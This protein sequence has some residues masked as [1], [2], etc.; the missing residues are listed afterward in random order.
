MR[1]FRLFRRFR[2]MPHARAAGRRATDHAIESIRE[3]ERA[4]IAR[5]LHDDLGQL[6][7]TLR[8]DV[9]L[10]LQRDAREPGVRE[11]LEGMDRRLLSA[12]VSLR[13]IASNLRPLVLDEGGLYFALQSLRNEFERRHGITCLLDAQESELMFDDYFSTAVYRIV[14]ESL[15]N[16]AR[17]AA[18]ESVHVALRRD[19]VALQI[20]IDDDGRGI[21]PG[22]FAKGT[23]FGLLGM[24]ER[25][26]ALRGDIDISG[27]ATGTRIHVALPLP[28]TF[29]GK[30]YP[31]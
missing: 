18:A 11:Q 29:S 17:H 20:D 6:L 31:T 21:R 26:Q 15:T 3:D 5:E 7:A 4:F 2:P 16:V 19:H 12:I 14:Q 23:S 27:G 8:V 13:R 25:V 9:N 28:G 22:D 24:R 10:L 1:P 30:E